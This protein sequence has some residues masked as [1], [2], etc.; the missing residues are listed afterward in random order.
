MVKLN[1]IRY[2]SGLVL[3]LLFRILFDFRKIYQ[4]FLA[5]LSNYQIVKQKALLLE[6]LFE[7]TYLC[8]LLREQ[9]PSFKEK[10][11]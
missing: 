10:Y 8:V 7:S 1:L 6:L 3:H 9:T 5:K 4:F 11:L 2:Q